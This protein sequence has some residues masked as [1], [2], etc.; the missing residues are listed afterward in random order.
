MVSPPFEIVQTTLS[1]IDPGVNRHLHA[2]ANSR[3]PGESALTDPMTS[4]PDRP[5]TQTATLRQ[6]AAGA[7]VSLSTA[8]RVLRGDS[9]PVD[10][11]LRQRVE[12]SARA[13]RYV[14]NVMARN[15]RRGTPTMIGLIVGNMLEPYYGEIAQAVTERAE[16]SHGAL[17]IV[18]NMQRD[19]LLE[20]KYCRQLW[21]HRVAGLILSG[22]LFDQ[23]SHGAELDALLRQMIGAG[24]LVATLSPRG[25]GMP[26]FSADN[27]QVGAAMAQHLL[28]RGHRDIGVLLGPPQS[29]VAQQRLRGAG[30]RLKAAKAR[31]HVLHTD[32]PGAD[33]SIAAIQLATAHPDLTGYILGSDSM[34]LAM[35]AALRALGRPEPAA[36][37]IIGVGNTRTL[38]QAL[39]TV[40]ISLGAC[41]RAA[42]DHIVAAVGRSPAPFFAQPLPVI[43]Q[44]RA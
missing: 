41:A 10:P 15:L 26:L 16:L 44:A 33:A 9:Y 20:L 42:L 13:L 22:G 43:V 34:A 6:V 19:P 17:A 3:V 21:E 30:R 37:S 23:W 31:F 8:A 36:G 14:P 7:N 25:P 40:D 29:E 32:N 35:L 27:L 2:V 4:T 39:A 18:C 5:P 28:D 12:D 24:V 1:G 38:P 11:A